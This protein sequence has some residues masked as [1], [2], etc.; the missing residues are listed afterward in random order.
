MLGKI[1]GFATQQ[2]EWAYLPSCMAS[3][4]VSMILSTEQ[5]VNEKHFRTHLSMKITSYKL[6]Q[7][8]YFC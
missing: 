2:E 3:L 6:P 4:L 1:S 7:L 5:Q 8:A